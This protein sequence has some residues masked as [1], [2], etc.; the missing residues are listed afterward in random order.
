MMNRIASL[1][2]VDIKWQLMTTNRRRQP[3]ARILADVHGH[4]RAAWWEKRTLAVIALVALMATG[5]LG[6]EAL[7]DEKHRELTPA[8]IGAM[9]PLELTFVPERYK[10]DI[11]RS[12]FAELERDIQG[13][14]SR[15]KLWTDAPEMCEPLR[16]RLFAWEDITILEPVVRTNDYWSPKMAPYR[17]NCQKTA[18]DWPPGLHFQEA[19]PPILLRYTPF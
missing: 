13:D 7:A 16:K 14:L 6:R 11:F 18:E 3:V 19:T 12:F 1:N 15:L 5:F 10:E 17:K 9:S 8:E 2:L 4:T